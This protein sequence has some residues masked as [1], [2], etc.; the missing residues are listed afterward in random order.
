[1]NKYS[2]KAILLLL[3]MLLAAESFASAGDVAK[4]YVMFTYGEKFDDVSSFVHSNPDTW[5]IPG[6]RNPS[7]I[8]LVKDANIKL[9]D[10]GVYSGFIGRDLIFLEVYDG[11]VNPAYS[12]SSIYS[13][14]KRLV[15][16]FFYASLLQNKNRLKGMV[17]N[18]E[19]IDFGGATKASY[20]D[21]DVY[22]Q[23]LGILPILRSSD[24]SN[25]IK[26]KSVTYK[27]P[28]G[29]N[30]FELKLVKIGNTWKVDSRENLNVPLE[31][32][33]R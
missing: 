5:M 20:G 33:F 3:S 12:L 16:E 14:Q 28:L 24:P 32:F 30:G 22:A 25:D 17:T 8:A 21:M 18:I 1:M 27:V 13:L 19:N 26:S 6:E 11:K 10:P 7:A 15:L 9:N 4:K 31:F 29:K 23:I 2:K